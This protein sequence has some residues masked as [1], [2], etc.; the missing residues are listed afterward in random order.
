VVA[1]SLQKD[2]LMYQAKQAGRG[3]IVVDVR[4]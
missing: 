3:Q 2:L 1:V 4:R